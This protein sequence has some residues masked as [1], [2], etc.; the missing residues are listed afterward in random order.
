MKK[1]CFLFFLVTLQIILLGC[2]AL[3]PHD[4][5]NRVVPPDDFFNRKVVIEHSRFPKYT[6]CSL[7]KYL[8]GMKPGKWQKVSDA[9]WL[10]NMKN[11]KFDIYVLFIKH[12]LR[13]DAVMFQ[14]VVINGK[15]VSEDGLLT[16][17]NYTLSEVESDV[18]KSNDV[19]SDGVLTL[20]NADLPEA[21]KALPEKPANQMTQKAATALPAAATEAPETATVPPAAKAIPT[22][23]ALV[24]SAEKET[25]ATGVTQKT[26]QSSLETPV[27]VAPVKIMP[28]TEAQP[29]AAA[30]PATI[31]EQTSR[32]VAQETPTAETQK[33][34]VIG[35]RDSKR[36][37]LPGMK[38]Y[39]AVKA[40]HRVEFESEADAIKAG[41]Y[42]ASR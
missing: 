1:W 30:M 3:R 22:E 20:F 24:T 19:S 28:I 18:M 40:Y 2:N 15:A 31:T 34:K 10:Y 35:N 38:Y 13:Q 16:L 6:Q 7:D 8:K 37:H 39:H 26:V 21:K 4:L 33:I 5:S 29:V 9:Q 17:F 25:P 36:Y 41:Y 27:T 14:R 11:E 42:K 12:P 23:P 32:A